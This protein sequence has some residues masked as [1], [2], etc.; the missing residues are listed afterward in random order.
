MKI[1]IYAQNYKW[2]ANKL[3]SGQ[4]K[5][6]IDALID[7]RGILISKLLFHFRQGFRFVA[8]LF[9]FFPKIRNPDDAV[10]ACALVVVFDNFSEF[11]ILRDP[12]I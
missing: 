10:I 2:R 11:F 5:Q 3:K 7:I 8:R 12:G 6:D 4:I 1:S 9:L